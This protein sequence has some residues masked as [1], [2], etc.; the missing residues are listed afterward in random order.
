MGYICTKTIIMTY[1]N[2][3]DTLKF[4]NYCS[5]HSSE[6]IFQTNCFAPI[7]CTNHFFEMFLK[8]IDKRKTG[9]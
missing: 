4:L 5:L 8:E 1:E 6:P 2:Y 3:F 7:F 9:S